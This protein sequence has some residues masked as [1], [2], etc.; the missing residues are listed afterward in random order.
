MMEKEDGFVCI[1]E[2]CRELEQKDCPTSWKTFKST[3]LGQDFKGDI[4]A[5]NFNLKYF[6]EK[7]LSSPI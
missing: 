7:V 3:V 5:S 2:M 6:W 4:K 1:W